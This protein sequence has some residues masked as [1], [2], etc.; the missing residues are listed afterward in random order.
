MSEPVL[1][2]R[3]PQHFAPA[4]AAEIRQQAALSRSNPLGGGT[5]HQRH[6]G[7][8]DSLAALVS[9]LT[10]DDQRLVALH[11]I[12]SM[13]ETFKGSWAPTSS[14]M[15]VLGNAGRSMTNTVPS[16]DALL[17]ELVAVALEDLEAFY[18]QRVARRDEQA[19]REVRDVRREAAEISG[20]A[21]AQISQARAAQRTAEGERDRLK[22]ELK[23]ALAR[24]S[25]EAAEEVRAERREV[26]REAGAH[27]RKKHPEHEHVYH[28]RSEGGVE[29]F[30]VNYR[31]DGKSRFKSFKTNLEAALKWR[32]EHYGLV[33]PEE[34]VRREPVVVGAISNGGEAWD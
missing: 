2:R 21:K 34:P 20:T 3:A 12:A 26:A 31:E 11:K 10:Q 13:T 7:A 27:D 18:G 23:V 15:R 14:Q 28:R 29:S 25:E 1:G 24:L 4:V 33:E 5:S 16:P 22:Y 17:T 9:T 8:L 6:V 30:E 32:D 19:R